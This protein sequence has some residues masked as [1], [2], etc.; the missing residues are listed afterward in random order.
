M[1]TPPSL[2]SRSRKQVP[3]T[4]RF[5]ERALLN[6]V[7]R[8]LRKPCDHIAIYDR[9]KR[10][11]FFFEKKTLTSTIQ[12]INLDFRDRIEVTCSLASAEVL[13]VLFSAIKSSTGCAVL[14]CSSAFDW[15]IICERPG[16]CNRGA[17]FIGDDMALR[18]NS[19][20]FAADRQSP[21]LDKGRSLPA[22]ESGD[23]CGHSSCSIG[24]QYFLFEP[25]LSGQ[26]TA[27]GSRWPR[28]QLGGATQ[29]LHV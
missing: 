26:W 25:C 22:L 8:K 18:G 24:R 27:L 16:S 3:S 14:V 5:L 10:E 9:Q 13:L 6:R 28:N 17:V 20:S 2:R 11:R 1:L 29:R 4:H 21:L 19:C 12:I 7:Y 23:K 15:R